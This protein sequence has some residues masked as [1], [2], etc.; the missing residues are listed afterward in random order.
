MGDGIQFEPLPAERVEFTPPVQQEPKSR[1]W[2]GIAFIRLLSLL[3]VG[4]A[5]YYST[6]GL[7]AMFVLFILIVPVE[8]LFP[9]HRGQKV[10]RPLYKLDMSYAMSS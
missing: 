2:L 7:V 6:E 5:V 10:R 3:I 4:A 9:R 8:K 1:G